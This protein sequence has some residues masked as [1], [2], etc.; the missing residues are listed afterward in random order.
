MKIRRVTPETYPKVVG[1]LKQSFVRGTYEVALVEKLHRGKKDI[2]EW[3][4]IHINKV[5]AYIAFT[6]AYNG[7]DICGLHLAPIAVKPEY[8]YQGIGSELIR[9]A[10]RQEKI[11][12][13]TVF[14][15]GNPELYKKFG[16]RPCEN[17]LCPFTKN[18]RHFQSIRNNYTEEFTV[19]YENEF[20]EHLFL[21]T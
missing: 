4:C 11:Q 18:N 10:L 7:K 3:V 21:K 2:D 14:V 1:L 17:P 9:F 5:I 15:L 13:S 16:F 20:G 8:Q 6:K 19:G 12:N